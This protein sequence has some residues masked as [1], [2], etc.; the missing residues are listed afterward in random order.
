[1]ATY[2]EDVATEVHAA[3]ET[4]LVG[5]YLHGSA[6]LG[7]FDTRRSDVDIVVVSGGAVPRATRAAVAE[8]LGEDALP[9]PARGL[10][11]S[12]VT[13]AAALAPSAHPPFELHVA[14]APGDSKVVDGD[15]VGGDPDLVLHFAVCRAA[16]RL[17]GAG[18]SPR[19]AFAPVPRALVLAQLATELAWGVANA[20]DEYAVLN[21]CRAWRFVADGAIVSKI[22]GGE[23]ALSQ[24]EE[25]EHER[26]IVTALA[27]QRCIVAPTF[28]QAS[29]SRFVETVQQRVAA[30]PV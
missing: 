20:P 13:H 7:G 22:S 19:E 8:S 9:C 28:D 14:T 5:V 10:E 30:A 12:V 24:L 27:R 18:T 29:V 1:M 11:L 3:L 6:V 15:G 25:H 26:T 16:G 17:V 21:A 4:S 2:V 23:W